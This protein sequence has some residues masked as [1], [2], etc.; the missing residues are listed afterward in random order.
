MR[1]IFPDLVRE[2]KLEGN[3]QLDSLDPVASL[4]DADFMRIEDNGAD[5]T[6]FAF[7]G[8][9]VLYAGHSRYHLMAVVKRLGRRFGGANFVF[10]RDCRR[11]GFM[12][13]PDG[14][15][16]GWDFYADVV[17]STMSDLGA[18]H[19][20]AIGSS[21]GGSVAHYMAYRC[22]MQQVITFSA[23]FNAD[24]YLRM[25]NILKSLFNLKQLVKEPRGYLEVLLVTG[26]TS[27][28]FK[29]LKETVGLEDTPDLVADYG[30]LENKPAVTLFYGDASPPD[31]AQAQLMSGF[32]D[33][34]LVPVPTGRHNTPGFLYSQG[35]LGSAI[36]GEISSVL[37]RSAKNP[38]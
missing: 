6:I 11:L 36:A 26:S 38:A 9:D 5:V 21:Y 20:V 17:S 27:W 34:K 4:T 2:L 1:I 19:N 22:G 8:V 10:L 32:S 30:S 12:L 29:M 31:A 16:G 23:L 35:K 18:T 37:E 33:V 3:F 14:K 15:P 28:C 7:S 25:K 24:S 13:R